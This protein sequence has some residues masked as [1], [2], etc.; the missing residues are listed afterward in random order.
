[1]TATE[2]LAIFVFL[3]A[4]IFFVFK[5]GFTSG[6]EKMLMSLH[7][8]GWLTQAAIRELDLNEEEERG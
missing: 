8:S 6:A 2:V 4:M 1:M 5:S 3:P 7:A